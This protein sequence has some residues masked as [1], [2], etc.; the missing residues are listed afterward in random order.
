M[1]NPQPQIVPRRAR[2]LG[3]AL[4]GTVWLLF[5]LHAADALAAGLARTLHR[6]IVQS[7]LE[8]IV[9][10]G[11]LLL[12]FTALQRLTDGTGSM[13]IANAL[14]PRPSAHQE[15]LRGAALGWGLFL[16]LALPL[17][18]VGDLHPQLGNTPGSA[19]QTLVTLLSIAFASLAVE[20]AFRGFLFQQLRAVFG[21]SLAVFVLSLLFALINASLPYSTGLS[22]LTSFLA[23]L[24][25][26]LCYLRTHGLWLGWGVR[27]GWYT[28]VGVL[29]GM[30]LA[31]YPSFSS[32]V[33][34]SVSGADWL[35]G[36]SYGPS[37]SLL[38]V[39]VLLLAMPVLYRITREYA[40]NYTHAP[41]E[42]KGYA[43]TI[44]PPAAHTQMESAVGP[45]PPPPPLVQIL[46]TTPA[47][48]STH[49]E[50][51]AALRRPQTP[52]EQ[53]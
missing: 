23:A 42:P 1:P 47:A 8:Q 34:T 15:W 45:P 50:V 20:V 35:T 49:A 10:L 32:I 36:G 12:G 5:S 9:L 39:P 17:M 3:S 21:T 48:A 25:Y 43:V 13:R 16:V 30:P 11:L 4:L 37:A 29:F 52:P 41:I 19:A 38:A 18:L 6:Q 26:S 2:H 7:L 27:F 53:P 14:P 44:A 28:T 46:P 51:E 22:F 40:W 24:F 31:G 33:S